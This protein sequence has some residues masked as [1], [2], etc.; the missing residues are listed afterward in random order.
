MQGDTYVTADANE[1]LA[2]IL[3]SCIAACIRDPR[4]SSVG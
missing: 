3:G 4:P 2:T 1:V